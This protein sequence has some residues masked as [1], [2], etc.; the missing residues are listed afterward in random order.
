MLAGV[1]CCVAH[2]HVSDLL[3]SREQVTLHVWEWGEWVVP[4]AEAC[5]LIFHGMVSTGRRTL[6]RDTCTI[7]LHG[8]KLY[9]CWQCLWAGAPKSMSSIRLWEG[10]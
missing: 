8:T 10:H 9:I 6:N 5:S 2:D 7:G 3:E 1:R 4:V